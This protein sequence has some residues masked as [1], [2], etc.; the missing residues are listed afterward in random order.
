MR[1]GAMI[2]IMIMIKICSSNFD[3]RLWSLMIISP[4]EETLEPTAEGEDNQ[5]DEQWGSEYRKEANKY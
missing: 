1:R 4:S 2:M 3:I 5:K